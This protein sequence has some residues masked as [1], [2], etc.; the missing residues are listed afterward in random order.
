LVLSLG[1]YAGQDIEASPTGLLQF[2]G[3]GLMTSGFD[4]QY[5]TSLFVMITVAW[6]NVAQ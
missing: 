6:M 5:R 3:K 2:V 1:E 4:F